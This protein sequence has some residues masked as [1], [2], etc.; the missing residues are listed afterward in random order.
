MA[1][2]AGKMD[3]LDIRIHASPG[4]EF[5]QRAVRAPV[6]HQN[7]LHAAF[8]LRPKLLELCS[9]E[10]H[11]LFLVVHR[12]YEGKNLRIRPRLEQ[13]PGLSAH[14]T[15]TL[16]TAIVFSRVRGLLFVTFWR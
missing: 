13:V 3:D 7:D 4:G 8:D 11:H 5:G 14:S 15:S 2:V 10:L 6:I 12:N 9:Q 1:E 16:A